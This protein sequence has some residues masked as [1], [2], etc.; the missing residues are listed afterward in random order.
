MYRRRCD[1][2]VCAG[3]DGIGTESERDSGESGYTGCGG[4]RE[5]NLQVEERPGVA[6]AVH[7]EERDRERAWEVGADG[8]GRLRV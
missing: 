4:P 6:H 3:S 7:C 1:E 8:G 5:R 2:G